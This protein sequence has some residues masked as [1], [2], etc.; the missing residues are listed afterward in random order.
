[1][2]I[3]TGGVITGV[4]TANVEPSSREHFSMKLIFG[5]FIADLN[6]VF[7]T[8]VCGFGTVGMS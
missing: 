8:C 2:F 4:A 5:M 6:S 3:L 7:Q 1:V